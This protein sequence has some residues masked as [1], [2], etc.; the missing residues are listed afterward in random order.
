[1]SI[2]ERTNFVF[3]H[4]QKNS[5]DSIS[6]LGEDSR[7][8]CS[9]TY[10]HSMKTPHAVSNM[11]VPFTRMRTTD[12]RIEGNDGELFGEIHEIPTGTMRLIRKW[13]VYDQK[14]TYK[15]VVTEKPKFIGSDWV[16]KDVEDNLLA[17]AEGDRKKNNYEI[18]APDGGKQCIARCSSLDK[19]SY[20]VELMISS[21][22]SFLVLSYVIVLDLAKTVYTVVKSPFYLTP[23]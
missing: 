4:E 14:G 3:K 11:P 2:F 8:L 22:D 13:Q 9:V 7:P 12:V 18:V 16:L 6:I 15:G 17:V 1:M 21:I 10:D 5:K 19:D 20:R 23:K